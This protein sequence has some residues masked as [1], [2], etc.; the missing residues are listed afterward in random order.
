MVSRFDLHD[1]E[2][3][4]LFGTESQMVEEIVKNPRLIEDGFKPHHQ[5]VED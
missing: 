3:L 4:Y 2:E 5:G 1:D